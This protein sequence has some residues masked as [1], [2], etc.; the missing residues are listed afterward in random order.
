MHTIILPLLEP[1]RTLCRLS[2]CWWCV[3]WAEDGVDRLTSLLSEICS[4]LWSCT[5]LTSVWPLQ[6]IALC[7]VILAGFIVD[8]V[9]STVSSHLNGLVTPCIH[10]EWMFCTACMPKSHIL[11]C[12]MGVAVLRNVFHVISPIDTLLCSLSTLNVVPNFCVTESIIRR[13]MVM[14]HTVSSCRKQ[15]FRLSELVSYILCTV[16]IDCSN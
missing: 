15:L 4:I 3:A 14:T 11:I 7:F 6:G 13:H 9:S 1:C 16:L 10:C 8:N 5:D 12:P 2:R